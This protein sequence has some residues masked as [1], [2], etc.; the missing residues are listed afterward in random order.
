[1]SS[2]SPQYNLKAVIHE[3]GLTPATLRAWERRYGV[4]KPQR[5]AGGHRLYSQE[6][7]E[8]LKWLVRRKSEGLSISRAVDLWRS[9][10]DSARLQSQ[11]APLFTAGETMLDQLRQSWIEAC[12]SFDEPKAEQA[13]AQSLALASPEVVCSEVLQKGLA[14]LGEGWYVGS[15]TVQQEH[16]ASALAARRLHALM[17][18]APTPFRSGRLLAACPPG[19]EHDLALLMLSFILRWRGWEVVYLGAN[20]PLDRLDATLKSTGV[21]LVLS[22]AQTL[23]GAA[24]LSKLADFLD[25]QSIP[26]GYGGGIFNQLPS[27][28]T[29]IHAHFLGPDLGAVPAAVENLIDRSPRLARPAPLAPDYQIALDGFKTREALIQRSV[30]QSLEHSQIEPQHLEEANKNFTLAI[31]SALTLGDI[32][33]LDHSVGWLDGLLRNHNLPKKLAHEYFS[34]YQEAVRLHLGAQAGPVLSWFEHLPA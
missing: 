27:L 25:A 3:T 14:A 10:E 33:A 12:L 19:E 8:M 34:A 22:V 9:Q 5:S 6:Q 28:T 4:L 31:L 15:V 1:M 2:H 13:L 21:R 7:I 11:P 17:A 32:E 18:V 26:L 16:F 23:A 20:V 29:R 30:A 24:S